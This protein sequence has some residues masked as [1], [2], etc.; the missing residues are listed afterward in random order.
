M[1][2]ITT[3]MKRERVCLYLYVS[4]CVCEREHK[5]VLV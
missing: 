1:K 3:R 5:K 4:V 2:K